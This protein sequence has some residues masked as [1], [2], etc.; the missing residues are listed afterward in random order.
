[1]E[2]EKHDLWNGKTGGQPWMQR[3]LITWL[4]L[5]DI[6]ILYFMMGWVVPFY[7]LCN[8]KGYTSTYNFF[9]KRFAFSPLKS[10]RYVYLN[11]F[12]FGQIILD[13]FAFYAGKTFKFE[14]DG[15][16]RF[17][18]L[19]SREEGFLQLSSHIGNYELAGYSLVAK[20]KHFNVLVFSGETETIMRNRA[21]VLSKN[22]MCMIPVKEDMSHVFLLNKALNNGEIVSMPGDRIFGSPKYVECLFFGEKAKFPIG[23]FAVA[24][25]R[26]VQVLAVFVMKESVDKYKIFIREVNIGSAEE[27]Q[28]SQKEKMEKLAKVFATELEKVVRMYPVQWFNYY[29]FWSH[30]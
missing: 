27:G 11:H 25:Q 28:L 13:R 3:M 6:R 7:M 8:R 16:E 24:V 12:R 14:I 22:K 18:H 26:K 29:D 2:I 20:E 30:L 15:Y 9:R 5:M 19:A 10:F 17:K 23:P 4:R 1:M 21:R